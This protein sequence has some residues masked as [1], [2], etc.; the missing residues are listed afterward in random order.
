MSINIADYE[1][2]AHDAVKAFWG[3]RQAAR[4]QQQVSGKADQGERAGVTAGKNMDNFLALLS[5]IVRD[6]GLTGGR[7]SLKALYPHS[8]RLFSP[9]KAL[10]Y[11]DYVQR[12]ANRRHRAKESGW[13][14]VRK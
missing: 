2:K 6:N 8:P 12:T 3:N 11:A 14:F 10:G 5:D 1:I 9:D 7:N 13:P 4:L